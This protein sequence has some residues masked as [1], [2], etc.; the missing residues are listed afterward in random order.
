[1]QSTHRA[2]Y[3]TPTLPSP[4]S[5]GKRRELMERYLIEKIAK[6]IANEEERP[7]S[8]PNYISTSH[9]HFNVPG[10]DPESGLKPRFEYGLYSD[11]PITFWSENRNRTPGVTMSNGPAG[12]FR[13]S[14]GFIFQFDEE[15]STNDNFLKVHQ[16]ELVE[17]SKEQ[18]EDMGNLV[19][20]RL[21]PRGNIRMSNVSFVFSNMNATICTRNRRDDQEDFRDVR[22]EINQLLD[23]Y[24]SSE[25]I[26]NEKFSIFLTSWYSFKQEYFNLLWESDERSLK[27]QQKRMERKL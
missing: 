12:D 7:S 21:C 13:H 9:E 5:R 1:M 23:V 4:P 17:V 16:I 26:F 25:I 10:F 27:R 3:K 2:D 6:D 15:T 8:P 20:M 24:N 18:Q 14:S 22:I 19:N 11:A